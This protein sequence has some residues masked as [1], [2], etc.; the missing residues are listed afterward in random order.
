M[1]SGSCHNETIEI[2]RP[3]QKSASASVVKQF[4]DQN[5]LGIN[6]AYMMAINKNYTWAKQES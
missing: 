2:T 3:T 5:E 6:K 4:R 1:S